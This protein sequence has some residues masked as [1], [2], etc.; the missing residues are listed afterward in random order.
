MIFKKSSTCTWVNS[1]NDK[2][3]YKVKNICQLCPHSLVPVEGSVNYSL[4]KK[5]HFQLIVICICS[6]LVA[7][8]SSY[9]SNCSHFPFMNHT[10]TFLSS[11]L[12]MDICPV[13][14]PASR[15]LPLQGKSIL[16]S[17]YRRFGVRGFCWSCPR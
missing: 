15:P 17:G 14:P 12:W 13:V 2:E 11:V 6:G 8:V 9:F 10:L 4:R 16:K 3:W 5:A 7:S 1:F